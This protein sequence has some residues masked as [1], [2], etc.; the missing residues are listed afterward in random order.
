[1][2]KILIIDDDQSTRESLEMY[3]S[4]CG[5]IVYLASDGIDGLNLIKEREPDVVISDNL[6][7]NLSGLELASEL[8]ELRKQIPFILISSNKYSDE[9]FEDLQIFAYME[10]PIDINELT[11]NI[12]RALT[13]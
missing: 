5:Y 2:K 7:P 3:F 8:L 9:I 12:T 10:K 6:M 11:N 13:G 4:E 1:M